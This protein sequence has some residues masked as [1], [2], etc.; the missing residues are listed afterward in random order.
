[1]KPFWYECGE[2]ENEKSEYFGRMMR[3]VSCALVLWW[4]ISTAAMAQTAVNVPDGRVA[5]REW[6]M[7]T[8][9]NSTIAANDTLNERMVDLVQV[10]VADSVVRK[11]RQHHRVFMVG[12]LIHAFGGYNWRA[13]SMTKRKF[14]GTVHRNSRSSEEHFTEYDINYDLYFLL[15]HYQRLNFA[16]YDRQREL[17]RQDYRRSHRRDYGVEPFVRDTLNF[18][19]MK[20]RL[21]CELTPPR[22]FRAALDAGFYPTLPGQGLGQHWSMG[23]ER[24]TLGVYGLWCLDCNHSCHPELHPYEWIWWLRASEGDTSTAKTWMVGL[25]HESSNRMPD[26]STAPV[27]GRISIPFA[28]GPEDV[29]KGEGNVVIEHLVHSGF[30]PALPAWPT[31]GCTAVTA[32]TDTQVIGLNTSKGEV[33]LQVRLNHPIRSDAY[34]LSVS[35]LV[36]DS[37][38]GTLCGRLNLAVSA[39]ELYTMKVTFS[40]AD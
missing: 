4:A 29:R 13:L 3:N 25:F 35:D 5:A 14:V 19:R 11:K 7:L 28:I 40:G 30:G 31:D 33:R 1:M 10:A 24:P 38:T 21:H 37:A 20:Y 18:D 9:R 16:A 15:P 39:T 12:W 8:G 23:T 22:A 17:K 34:A 26:W 6:L 36:L 2:S 32:K 27:Q